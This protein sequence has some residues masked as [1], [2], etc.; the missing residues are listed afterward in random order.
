MTEKLEDR[1]HERDFPVL[2]A[3]A[4]RLERDGI[5]FLSNNLSV[6]LEMTND[7]VG[8]ALAALVPSHLEG[9]RMELAIAGPG[10][11]IVTGITE[12][13]RRATGLW[14]DQEQ[15]AAALIELLTQAADQVDDADDAG[16]L[17][18]AGRLLRSVPGA[19]LADVTAALIRQQAGLN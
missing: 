6:E 15:A 5:A 11:Y 3:A 13:G 10:E 9:K 18:K 12:R 8:L 14:P 2:I 1:W 17:R 19:V 4:R 16:A 7:D